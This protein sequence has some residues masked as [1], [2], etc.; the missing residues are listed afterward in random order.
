[1]GPV[2]HRPL[3]VGPLPLRCRRVTASPADPALSPPEPLSARETG[4]EPSPAHEGVPPHLEPP[5]REWA[6]GYLGA[7]LERRVALQLEV[8][9]TP[10]TRLP[11]QVGPPQRLAEHP[12]VDLLDVADVA[13]QLDHELA[14]ELDRLEQERTTGITSS[15]TSRRRLVAVAALGKLL[16]DAHSAYQLDR[17]ARPVRLTRRVD[18]TVQAATDEATRTADPTA[19]HLLGQAWTA[20]YSRTPDPTASYRDAI[21]A[22]ETVA[23]PLVLPDEPAA[24]LGKVNAHLRQ[25]HHK[26]ELVLLDRDDDGSVEPLVR[27]LERLWEGQVSRHGGGPR[28]RDQTL[29]EARAAVQLAVL[30]V[31]WLSAG[32]LHRRTAAG[33]AA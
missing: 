14:D 30:C 9:L 17:G 1:M 5:L 22:V 10:R 33:G 28:S 18:P 12:E 13:L 6:R 7:E 21:R 20:A 26:W 31:Q 2:R 19:R 29:D 16:D 23:R 8:A 27:M 25:A 11:S 24:T 32:V 4:R 3:V 15:G